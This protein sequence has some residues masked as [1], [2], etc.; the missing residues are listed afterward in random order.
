MNTIAALMLKAPRPGTVKTRLAA[1]IG[2]MNAT[3]V[4]RRLVEN[5]IRQ[6]PSGWGIRIYF[7]PEE[8]AGEMKD[9]LGTIAPGAL[10]VPQVQGDLGG[11]MFAAVQRELSEGADAVALI[12]GDCPALTSDYLRNAEQC[13]GTSDIVL[14]PALDGGYVLML[15]KT[16]CCALFEG[17][18]WSTSMVLEQTLHAAEIKNMTFTLMEPLEDIDDLSSLSRFP[19]FQACTLFLRK[20]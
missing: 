14:G 20:L 6:I 5:Q 10:Y 9:W 18:N 19:C 12:G 1:E 17:I 2:E 3:Q 4:Y 13:L 16:A 11:R 8:A 15:L 7:S